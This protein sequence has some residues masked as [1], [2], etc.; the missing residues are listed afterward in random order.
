M[1]TD[2]SD[3]QTAIAAVVSATSGARVVALSVDEDSEVLPLAQA[4]ISGYVTRDASLAD[5]AAAIEA[6]ACG[7]LSCSARVAGGLL[8]RVALLARER[9]PE[10]DRRLTRREHEIV[11]LIGSGLSNREIGEQLFIEPATVK[12]HVHNILTKLHVSCRGDAVASLHHAAQSSG[13]GAS[14]RRA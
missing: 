9:E 13:P 1:N 3:A 11:R 10:G 14:H 5:V 7:E 4:G 6:A 8:R 12:N 2:V